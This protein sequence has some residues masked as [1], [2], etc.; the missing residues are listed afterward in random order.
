VTFFYHHQNLFFDLTVK[1]QATLCLPLA[2]TRAMTLWVSHVLFFSINPE[3]VLL[4]ITAST[5]LQ[6]FFILRQLKIFHLSLIFALL[7]CQPF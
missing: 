2:L 1:T 6:T 5:R 3:M 4:V 7:F